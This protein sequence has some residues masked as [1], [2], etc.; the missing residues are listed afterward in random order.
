MGKV[1]GIAYRTIATNLINKAGYVNTVAQ[2]G[3]AKPIF[4]A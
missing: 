4:F 1:L 2:T 3:A